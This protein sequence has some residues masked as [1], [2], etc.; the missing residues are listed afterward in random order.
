[1][2]LSNKILLGFFGFI[3]LYLT[4]AFAELRMKGTPN[5]IDDKNSIAETV[6]ISGITYLVLSDVDKT[7]NVIGSDRAQLEVRS[8]SGDLLKKLTYKLSGD[9]LILSGFQSEAIKTMKISVF[10]PR[11]SLKSIAV[12]SSSVVVKG[13]HQD[14]LRISQKSANIWITDI[15]IGKLDVDLDRSYL[16]I[17]AAHLDTVSATIEKSTANIFTPVGM[18]Q[19]NL[20]NNAFLRMTDIEEI[21]LTKDITSKLTLY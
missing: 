17:S 2:N 13:L 19:G 11:A 18:L 12:N 15:T 5:V 1:M 16:D 20:K 6:D 3:F 8:L 4:A 7:I 14:L 21:Q 10:V 9:T